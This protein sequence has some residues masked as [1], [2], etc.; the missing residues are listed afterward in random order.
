MSAG[1]NGVFES[2]IRADS[3]TP[4]TASDDLIVKDGVPLAR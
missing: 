2:S 1:P 4:R 3:V